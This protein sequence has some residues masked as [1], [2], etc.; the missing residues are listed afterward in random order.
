MPPGPLRIGLIEADNVQIKPSRREY[1]AKT[2]IEIRHL[3]APDFIYPDHLQKGIRSV[4][5]SYGFHPSGR[6]RPASEF[7]VKDLQARGCFN[8]IN[9]AVDINNHLSLLSHLPISILDRAKTGDHLCIRTGTD[10]EKYIF[11][12]EGHELTLKNLLIIASGEHQNTPFGSPVK[13]SQ[14]TKIFQETKSLV[15]I[16]YTSANVSPYDDLKTLLGRFAELL[17]AETQAENI[18]WTI[19][20]API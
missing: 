1:L 12:K 6:N 7:L 16:I 3:L 2:E 4:L 8:P 13:D 19:Y 18:D 9:N 14:S 5:K 15:G 11:N 20:D 17:A 10:Q